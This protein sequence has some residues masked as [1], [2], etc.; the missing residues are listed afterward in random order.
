MRKRKPYPV[1]RRQRLLN[2][3][4]LES[5][6]CYRARAYLA[7]SVLLAAALE[8]ALIG[9]A[10]LFPSKVRRTR[11]WRSVHQRRR[12]ILYWDLAELIR[13]ANETGWLP[14]KFAD[15]ASASWAAVERDGTIGDFVHVVRET[16]NLIHPGKYLRDYPTLRYRAAHYRDCYAIISAAMEWLR[17]HVEADLRRRLGLDDA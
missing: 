13:L 17:H 10:T 1:S 7:A 6:R 15:D 14:A 11:T 9:M 8:A 3:Y 4:R 12:S 16:R 2:F 5:R